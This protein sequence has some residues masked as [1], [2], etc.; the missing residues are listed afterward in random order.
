MPYLHFDTYINMV[1]RRSIIKRRLSNGR[2]RP[3]PSEIAALESMEL[4]VIWQ[5]LEYDPPLNFR[6][7]LDQYGYP[8]LGDTD[9]R[10]DDQMLYKL[11]KEDEPE[12]VKSKKR[13]LDRLG[14][15]R[16]PTDHRTSSVNTTLLAGDD[17]KDSD[18]E[19]DADL[20]THIIDGKVLMVDQL[21]LWAVDTSQ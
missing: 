11:T 17:D 4:R 16:S 12:P 20:V 6:R 1:K 10:D 5:Y 7:S 14:S 13:T 15:T 2:A 3:V 8:S 18:I 9:A 19:D 21:W